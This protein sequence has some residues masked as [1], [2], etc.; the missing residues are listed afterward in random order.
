MSSMPMQKIKIREKHTLNSI[1]SIIKSKEPG[2]LVLEAAKESY[3][4]RTRAIAYKLVMGDDWKIKERKSITK[5]NP[6]ER[7]LA[8]VTL[9]RSSNHV[10]YG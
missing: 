9:I 10:S 6:R 7:K 3:N 1:K 4:P 2:V 5:R 8:K